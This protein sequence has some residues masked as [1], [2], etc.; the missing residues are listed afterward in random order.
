VKADGLKNRVD[1]VVTVI[2][3]AENAQAPIDFRERWN[4]EL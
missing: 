4:C 1:F 2:A 3:P